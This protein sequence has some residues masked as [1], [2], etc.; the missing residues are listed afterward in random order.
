MTAEE[1][2]KTI[3]ALAVNEIGYAEKAS[4]D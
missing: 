2:K 3:L 4:N 1:A